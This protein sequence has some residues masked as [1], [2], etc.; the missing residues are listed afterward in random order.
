[1]IDISKL[2]IKKQYLKDENGNPRSLD[3]ASAF[4][5]AN[6]NGVSVIPCFSFYDKNTKNIDKYI[7]LAFCKD[8]ELL[9]ETGKRL[10]K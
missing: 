3:Y 8:E 5:F 7:R 10:R 9:I 1:M 2:D 4:Q 6:E